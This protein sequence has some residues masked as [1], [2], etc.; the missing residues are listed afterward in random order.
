MH[1]GAFL[2]S[3]ELEARVCGGIHDRK[4]VYMPSATHRHPLHPVRLAGWAQWQWRMPCVSTHGAAMY[5]Q[6]SGSADQQASEP[7]Q[8]T[9]S[10]EPAKSAESEKKKDEPV[11]GEE[12]GTRGPHSQQGAVY[13]GTSRA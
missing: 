2:E 3:A 4:G 10:D 8:S 5:Q 9:E 12:D 1:L 11:E 6:S 13:P 7:A